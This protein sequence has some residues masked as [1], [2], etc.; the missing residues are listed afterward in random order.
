M[1]KRREYIPA[2]EL[3]K[4]L[5]KKPEH[6]EFF[7]LV[8]KFPIDDIKIDKNL[9]GHPDVSHRDVLEILMYFD[10][11]RW[12]PIHI[13]PDYFLMDGQHRLQVAKQLGLEYVDVVI[14]DE[15][16]MREK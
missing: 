12:D 7:E 1:G 6:H 5:Y 15:E 16:K 9:H 8:D 10:Q 2:A 14:I 13:D 11:E 4:N 3:T